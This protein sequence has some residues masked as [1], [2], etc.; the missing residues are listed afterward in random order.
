[1][2][3]NTIYSKIVPK[4]NIMFIKLIF[5]IF[6]FII[7]NAS[8][9]E[10]NWGLK[11]LEN[12]DYDKALY[13]ISFDAV[14]GDPIAQ[15][16]LGLMYKKGIGVEADKKEAFGWFL[17]AADSGHMLAKYALGKMYY[18]GDGVKKNYTKALNLFLDGSYLGHPA[19][20]IEVGNM[21]YFGQSV[22]KNYPKAHMWWSLAKEKGVEG[23]FNNLTKIENIMSE[24][25]LLEAFELYNNCQKK[26]LP[27]C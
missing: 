18:H 3:H 7:L 24:N 8:A 20:Q 25:Q 19:S 2:C 22:S 23:A 5:F 27:K 14:Q 10:L 12:G 26:T 17:L 4:L 15:Y 9:S 13:Y 16:N 1:M 6:C 21:Y 11:A